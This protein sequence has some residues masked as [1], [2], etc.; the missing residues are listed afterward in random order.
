MIIKLFFKFVIRGF[1]K[2]IVVFKKKKDI[3]CDEDIFGSEFDIENEDDDIV[4]RSGL[5]DVDNE[6]EIVV[7][8]CLRFV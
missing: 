5:D 6:G 1:I 4:S 2:F 3:E 8:K 7:E